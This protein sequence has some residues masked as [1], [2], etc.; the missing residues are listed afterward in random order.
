MW[1][2]IAKLV[3]VLTYETIFN[4]MTMLNAAD[5]NHLLMLIVILCLVDLMKW[6]IMS[7]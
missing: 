7:K 1:E 5:I 3:I 2:T 4:K 6:R